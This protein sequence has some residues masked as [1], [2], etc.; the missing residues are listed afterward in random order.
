MACTTYCRPPVK[1][2]PGKCTLND[3]KQALL[4]GERVQFCKKPKQSKLPRRKSNTHPHTIGM[5][6]RGRALAGKK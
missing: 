4:D 5:V 3:S 2:I 6:S 1:A